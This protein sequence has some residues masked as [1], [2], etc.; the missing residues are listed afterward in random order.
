MAAC[1]VRL[2]RDPEL[3]MRLGRNGRALVESQY[4]WARVAEMTERL[5]ERLV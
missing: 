2:L 3:R 1:V 4:S 5:Y